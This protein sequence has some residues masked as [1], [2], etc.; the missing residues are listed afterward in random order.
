M[1]G[2]SSAENAWPAVQNTKGALPVDLYDHLGPCGGMRERIFNE[3][4]QGIGNCR[5]VARNYDLMI[6]AGQRD[7]PAGRQRQMR[8]RADNLFGQL[9]Q[10]DP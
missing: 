1:C 10:I 7:R 6:D 9:T 3:I 8:H 2:R 4:A 5:S